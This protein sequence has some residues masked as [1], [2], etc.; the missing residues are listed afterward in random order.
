MGIY[1]DNKISGPDSSDNPI[2][3]VCCNQEKS[4]K[5]D[6]QIILSLPVKISQKFIHPKHLLI[7]PNIPHLES[8]CKRISSVSFQAL[9]WS[10]VKSSQEEQSL[11]LKSWWTTARCGGN[12]LGVSVLRRGGLTLWSRKMSEQWG[13]GEKSTLIETI[14]K[15][16]EIEDYFIIKPINNYYIIE[17]GRRGGRLQVGLAREEEEETM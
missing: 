5:R 12:W 10:G 17:N 16:N 2:W 6:L 14:L 11:E 1:N 7:T 8:Q 3:S 4:S 9:R 13:A 15:K